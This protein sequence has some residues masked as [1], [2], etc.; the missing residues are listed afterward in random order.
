MIC[1]D[2]LNLDRTFN[3]K[4][5]PV[6]VKLAEHNIIVAENLINFDL[7]DFEDPIISASR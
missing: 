1:I 5:F 3:A 2:T 4:T 6:H 7:I